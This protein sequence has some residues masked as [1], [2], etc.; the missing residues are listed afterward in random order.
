[1][2]VKLKTH[3]DEVIIEFLQ[4]LLECIN[5]TKYFWEGETA[6]NTVEDTFKL[7][8]ILNE[9]FSQI[10]DISQIKLENV[11][12]DIKTAFELENPYEIL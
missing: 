5:L 11:L 2:F 10:P 8:L 12:S 6:L 7:R 4:E 1:L 3:H 9:N